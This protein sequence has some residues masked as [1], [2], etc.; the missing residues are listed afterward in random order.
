RAALVCAAVLLSQSEVLATD[1][2]ASSAG[3]LAAPALA[4]CEEADRLSG[5][6]KQRALQRGLELA[7][8]AAAADPNDARA[9]FAVC[10]NLGK[11][12]Q[13]RGASLGDLGAVGRLR[14]ELDTAL[15]LAPGDSDALAAKGELLLALPWFLGGNARQGEALLRAALLKDPNNVAARRYLTEALKARGADDEAHALEAIGGA[16][17]AHDAPTAPADARQR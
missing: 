8:L 16:P 17:A 14:R 4:L 3:S 2:A 9:H 6:E 13:S 7:Q 15:A 11:Q 1:A 5:A 12:A 10:C